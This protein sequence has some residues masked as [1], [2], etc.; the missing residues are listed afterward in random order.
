MAGSSTQ[1]LHGLR[2]GGEVAIVGARVTDGAAD[3]E[4]RLEGPMPPEDSVPEGALVAALDGPGGGYAAA[5][6]DDRLTVRFF[7]AGDFDVDLAAGSILARP[8]PGRGEAMVP[9]LLSGNVLSLVLGLGGAAVLHASAVE[10]D[11]SAIAFAGPSGAGKSTAAALLCA[12][13]ARLVTDDAARVE[14]Q[15][16]LLMVH[17][18][19]SELRL[20]PQVEELA[21]SA[22]QVTRTTADGRIGVECPA[23]ED[24]TM[25]LA[26]VVFPRWPRQARSPEVRRLR[27]REAIHAFLRCPRVTGWRTI[28]PIRDHLDA[29]ARMAERVPAFTADL[30]QCR[31]SAA[32]FAGGLREALTRAGVR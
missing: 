28:E 2:L 32:D 27:P 4:V 31:L 11:H 25:P 19:P 3:F 9:V 21:E 5:L 16:G 14:E 15:D 26:G 29:S 7:G 18:G 12:A 20:R 10:I 1:L 24:D 17:R 23:V 8:A 13:G 6:R 30:P 22:G